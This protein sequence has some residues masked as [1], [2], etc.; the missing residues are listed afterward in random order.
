[1][2]AS[3]PASNYTPGKAALPVKHKWLLTVA[4]MG[5]SII[6]ILD[7]TIAN[8]A[9]PH[10]QTSLGATIDSVSWVLTSY[11]LATAVA[12]P[13]AGWLSD[14]FGSRRL[15]LLEHGAVDA[16]VDRRELRS[17]IA[18]VLRLMMHQPAPETPAEPA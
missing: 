3:T 17:R 1:M 12:M 15:F 16:I 14:R 9:I 11:I 8:V 13:S 4:V 18:A 2:S 6:Q 5:A 10:M 7:S